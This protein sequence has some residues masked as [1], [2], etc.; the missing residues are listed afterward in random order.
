MSLKSVTD[1]YRSLILQFNPI[2]AETVTPLQPQPGNETSD[3]HLLW[4][5]E[6]IQTSEEMGLTKSHRWLGFIQGVLVMKR[7]TTVA[8]EREATRGAYNE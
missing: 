8:D 1:R 5:I 6:E 3:L 7:Y 2:L 4:M